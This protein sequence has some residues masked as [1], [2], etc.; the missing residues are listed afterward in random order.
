MPTFRLGVDIGGT[1]TDIVLLES[2]GTVHTKKVLSTPDDYSA[3][4]ETGVAELLEESGVSAGDIIEFSHGTTVATNALIERKGVKVALV[5]TEGFRDILELG[6]IRTPRLYDLDFR[7]P[8]PL[9]ARRLRFE[10]AER[11]SGK[12]EVLV[13]VDRDGLERLADRMREQGVRAVAVCFI[14]AYVN[15]RNEFDATHRLQELLPDIPV[16][17]SA[18][19]LPQIQ[20]YER[21]STTVV[22]AYIRPVVE[23]YLAAL[24]SRMARVGL[25]VPL[26][27]MQSNGGVLPARLAGANPVYIIESGPAA[28]VVG[29]QRMAGGR[30]LGNVMVLDMGG[31]TAKAS[32]IEDGRFVIMPESEVGGDAAIGHR[33]LPGAGY[34]VQVP[35]IDIAEVGAGGGSIA[36]VDAAGGVRV[37]PL[38]AGAAPGPVC[39]GLGG[40]QPTVTDANLS[41]G[42]LNPQNLVGGDLVLDA[43]KSESAIAELG[44]RLGRSATATAY[45][46]HLIAN[47]NMMRALSSVSTERGRDPSGFALVTIGGSGGVHAAGL[48]ESLGIRRILVPPVAGLFSA[49]GLLFADVEHHLV[50]AYYRA[51]AD[52]SP[53][54]FNRAVQPQVDEARE[55]LRSGGFADAGPTGAGRRSQHEVRGPDLDPVGHLSGL[56]HNG[57]RHGGVG[58]R[59]RHP[60]L[61]AV[62][63]SLGRRGLAVRFPQGRRPW[64]FGDSAS[65][66]PGGPGG[67]ARRR[68]GRTQ[69]V[70]R[71]RSRMARHPRPASLGARGVG[72]RW[73][74]SRR[75][76]RYH[77][78]RSSGLARRAGRL[79][80]HRHRTGMTASS[81]SERMEIDPFKRELLKNALVTVADNMIVSVIRTARST[82]VKSNLDFSASICDAQGQLVAQGLALPVHMGATMPALKGCLDHYGNG[83]QPGDILANNDPYSGASHLNDIFMFKPVFRDGELLMF[84][85]LIL[86]H[87]DM[88]GR[89]PGGNATDSTEI[90]QEGLRIPPTKIV[91]AGRPNDTLMRIIQTNVR[92]P[93]KVLGDV[94]A[95]IASLDIAEREMLKLI[96]GYELAEFKAYMSDLIDYTERLTRAGIAALPDGSVAFT[97]WSDDDGAGNGP[98]KFHVTLT[99]EGDEMTVDFTGTSPQTT[100]A[101]NCNFWFTASCAYAAVRTLLDVSMPNNAGFYRPIRV[102]V[103]ER[104]FL[105][106]P[107]P[108]P[109]APADRPDTG[110]ARWFSG[111]SPSCC[112]SAYRPVPAARNSAS[113]WRATR[114]TANR[115]CS[116]SSTTSP[117]KE[118]V[119]TGTDRRADRSA[120]AI[121]PTCPSRSSRRNIPSASTP[122]PCFRTPAAPASIVAR[123]ESSANTGCWPTRRRCSCVPT[124]NTIARSACSGDKGVPSAGAYSIPETAPR[125]CRPSSS[126]PLAGTTSYAV[127]CR[128]PADTATPWNGT[129]S[130]WPTT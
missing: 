90:F 53:A 72:D 121:P 107:F 126:A 79:E 43:A 9:V 113:C 74:P 68:A 116:S 101:M 81:R 89:V 102:T 91:E 15:P 88:G 30:A 50:C 73:P 4:I 52:T 120:W 122:T 77:H 80:Q 110:R 6:R 23:T 103:P 49:L 2:D 115:S 42:Y 85:N 44:G 27:V 67:G 48:A 16:S 117:V 55:H 114:R 70:L 11:T 83:I 124:V 86:H 118:A 130:G 92:V 125:S 21:T 36:A 104:S 28:G 60:A 93:D 56:S 20:E 63:L 8:E 57:F 123:W 47:A 32:L 37:G 54:D 99:V 25:G 38:S 71:S 111:R 46:I 39:Y 94:R 5:T 59:L 76:I 17:A 128:V 1:F 98:V 22:N 51:F 35:T 75:G 26:N 19:L 96:E 129:R 127:K 69:G 14:N 65:P 61:K 13:P 18:Q 29:A 64:R 108:P 109:S 97:D 82:V 3:A 105:N 119:P 40:D 84:L 31:T 112:R 95:Q 24:E 10:V 33:L 66:R 34:P 41:L 12:G 78:R 100:G 62:R 106:A 7:K 58:R 87:T 45:G